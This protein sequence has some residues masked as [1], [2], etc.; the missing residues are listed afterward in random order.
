[1]RQQPTANVSRREFLW[2]FGGGLG[3]VAVSQLLGQQLLL[4]ESF[5]GKKEFNGGI[6]HPAKAKA[7]RAIVYVRRGEPMRHV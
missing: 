7:R 2:R 1:M 5:S 4:A 6:H 3:G